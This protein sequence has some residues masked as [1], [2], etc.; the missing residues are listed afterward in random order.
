MF[1]LSTCLAAACQES[2]Y[3]WAD[4]HTVC[5]LPKERILRKWDFKRSSGL[6]FSFSPLKTMMLWPGIM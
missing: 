2:L 3:M 5:Y 6:I 1:I 4:S